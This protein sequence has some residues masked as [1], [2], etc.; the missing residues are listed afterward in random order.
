MPIGGP[1]YIMAWN[2]LSVPVEEEIPAGVIVTYDS[3]NYTG[4]LAAS[5][6]TKGKMFL[7]ARSNSPETKDIYVTV[8]SNSGAHT[9]MKVGST[10]IDLS[11]Y[12]TETWVE[13]RDVDLTVA[14]YEQLVAND[15]I[16]PNKRYF[17]D[18]D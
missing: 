12:A 4:T 7:V 3:V 2:G 10:A 8:T 9:W 11:G 1:S 17:V 13:A 16:D 14:E 18:E 15:E 5:A 6:S